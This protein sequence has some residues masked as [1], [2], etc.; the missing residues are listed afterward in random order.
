LKPILP[1][2]IFIF[3]ISGVLDGCMGN[4]ELRSAP[5]PTTA[6]VKNNRSFQ[7]R[8]IKVPFESIFPKAIVVLMDDDFIIRS[9][10][11]G[12]GLISFY[13]QWVDKEQRDANFILEGTVFFEQAG[14][15]TTRIRVL[16]TGSWQIKSIGGLHSS[17]SMVGQF[18]PSPSAEQ[19]KAILDALEKGLLSNK[20]N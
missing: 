13:K 9:A 20:E 17:D 11:K 5:L 19:Y 15:D 8:L 16:M 18:E 4:I 3:L 10:N 2:V 1:I 6:E 7:T 14:A 12:L